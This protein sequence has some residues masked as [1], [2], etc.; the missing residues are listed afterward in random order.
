MPVYSI[1][2]AKDQFSKL[3]DQVIAGE[4]VTI[5]RHGKAVAELRAKTAAEGRWPSPELI[6]RIAARAKLR[7]PLWDTS[8][9]VVRELRDEKW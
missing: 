6:E 2:E 1:A 7:S 3:V 9:N 8:E 4:D 5:T